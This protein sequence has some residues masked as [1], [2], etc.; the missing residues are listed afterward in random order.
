MAIFHEIKESY[1][2]GGLLIRLI[3]IN[4]TVFV[5]LR[6]LMGFYS[7][8]DSGAASFPLLEWVSVPADLNLLLSRPWTLFT[9]MFVHFDFLHILFNL[10]CLYWFGRLFLHHFTS[11][12]LW[13][14]YWT[15]GAAGALL[16]LVA[17]NLIPALQHNS[18]ILM[19]A[20]ASSLAILFAVARYAPND[21]ITLV[22]IGE[23]S[24]K[25]IALVY[26]IIDLISIPTLAN[27]GGHLA[28]L[29]GA[30]AGLIWGSYAVRKTH[31]A[32]PGGPL[33]SMITTRLRPRAKMEVKHRRPLTDMEYN[34]IKNQRQRE[35]D[36]ILE[37]IKASGYDSLSS[38]EKKMLFDASK[39]S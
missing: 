2:S 3:Y 12:Q 29:G 34:Q 14:V 22:F 28:H 18:S 6:L 17:F 13:T 39:E 30:L 35:V 27:T 37:K 15:G 4:L 26:F 20:S 7:F 9:Y 31:S 36:R 1:R 11:R 25:Y 19:G 10:L 24:L 8:S 32:K 23:V 5:A 16:Y 38:A 21:R 33:F